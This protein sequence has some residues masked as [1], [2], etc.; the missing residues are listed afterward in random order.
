MDLSSGFDIPNPFGLLAADFDHDMDG[1]RAALGF[2][3][4]LAGGRPLVEALEANGGDQR[5]LKAWER[6]GKFRRVLAKAMAAVKRQEANPA[7]EPDPDCTCRDRRATLVPELHYHECPVWRRW[8]HANA[9]QKFV[10]AGEALGGV[11]MTIKSTR[12][13]IG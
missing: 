3:G 2:L 12:R 8:Y 11:K 1:Y 10:P 7:P 9:A 13:V 6:N 5:M 4:D